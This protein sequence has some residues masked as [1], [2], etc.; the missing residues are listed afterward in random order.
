MLR[1]LLICALLAFVYSIAWGLGSYALAPGGRYVDW[2]MQG[3][4][5]NWHQYR[6]FYQ[7]SGAG[8][9]LALLGSFVGLLAALLVVPSTCGAAALVF[10]RMPMLKERLLRANGVYLGCTVIGL[11]LLTGVALTIINGR[12]PG[13]P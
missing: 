5:H 10:W 8:E 9:W 7:E 4:S 3:V 2:T 1:P 6:W 11:G 13:V 12:N